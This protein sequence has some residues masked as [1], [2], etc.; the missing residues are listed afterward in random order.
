MLTLLLAAAAC[1]GSDVVHIL[2]RMRVTVRE[3]TV[4]VEGMR[5]DE[6]P[7]RYVSLR[8]R[9]RLGGDGLDRAQGERAVQLSLD[10]Y[11]SVV[12]SLAPDI[13]VGYEIELV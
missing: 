13:D 4:D 12:H 1:S 5:R 11:C 7:R 6:E 2:Q 9:F 8:F 10:K 3:V